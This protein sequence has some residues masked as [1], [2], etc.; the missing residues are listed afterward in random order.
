MDDE[1][2]DALFTEWEIFEGNDI[3][4]EIYQ[5]LKLASGSLEIDNGSH[6]SWNENSLGI[7]I[8]LPFEHAMSFAFEVE[9]GEE[10]FNFDDAPIHDYVYD[11]ITELILRACALM[12]DD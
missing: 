11:T 1:E 8:V 3:A 6:A 9:S 10:A 5:S 12:R 2:V 4:H 7:L